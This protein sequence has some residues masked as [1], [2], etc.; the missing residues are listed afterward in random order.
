MLGAVLDAT[1]YPT[2]PN[3][4]EPTRRGGRDVIDIRESTERVGMF[5][6]AFYWGI[7]LL[8][9]AFEAHSSKRS[10]SLSSCCRRGAVSGNLRPRSY[11]DLVPH[12]PEQ[13]L[14]AARYCLP[15]DAKDCRR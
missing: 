14:S 4:A 9:V 5:V 12:H 1:V 10:D 11:R 13:H 7:G 8:S 3:R 15:D 6:G 2:V